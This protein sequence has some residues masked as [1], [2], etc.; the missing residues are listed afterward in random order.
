MTPPEHVEHHASMVAAAVTAMLSGDASADIHAAGIDGVFDEHDDQAIS[1]GLL[2][3]VMRLLNEL[4]RT[5]G[6]E[7]QDVWRDVAF[8]IATRAADKT[9]DTEAPG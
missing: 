4:A 3:I 1:A 5:S 6:R 9:E 7:P 8:D 2:L